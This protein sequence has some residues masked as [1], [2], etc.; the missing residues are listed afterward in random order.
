MAE[1]LRIPAVML[2]AWN[3][4]QLCFCFEGRGRIMPSHGLIN[5]LFETRNPEIIFRDWIVTHILWH[6]TYNS[7]YAS[8]DIETLLDEHTELAARY[9]RLHSKGKSHVCPYMV[10][11]VIGK[12]NVL[13]MNSEYKTS[14]CGW[15]QIQPPRARSRIRYEPWLR[16]GCI[17][18]SGARPDD[19]T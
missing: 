10:L 12:A 13:V 17:S 5:I 14:R 4:F 1:Q 2:T 9:G 6:S 7:L 11:L 16:P 3:R 8:R 18:I 15:L 19:T